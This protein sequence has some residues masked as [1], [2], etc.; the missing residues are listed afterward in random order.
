V[1]IQRVGWSGP[2]VNLTNP[3]D[4]SV[5]LGPSGV[6]HLAVHTYRCTA[7][8]GC[9]SVSAD[10]VARI[11]VEPVL[12]IL[13]YEI[14]QGIQHYNRAGHTDNS[15]ELV[16]GKDTVIRLYAE[17]DIGTFNNGRIP[18][19][20]ATMGFMPV[21]QGY[22]EP[23]RDAD[24]NPITLLQPGDLD[25]TDATHTFNFLLRSWEVSGTLRFRFDVQV[26]DFGGRTAS[27]SRSQSGDR[28]SFTSVKE[29]KVVRV[30]YNWN[31][32]TPSVGDFNG[33]VISI[34]PITPVSAISFWVPEAE[35][36][37]IDTPHNLDT[38]DGLNDALDDLDELAD[39]YEDNG[40][41]WIGM[42]T[43]FN[44][45]MAMTGQ[46][47]QICYV[48]NRM[49]TSHELGHAT[50]LNHIETG[51][52]AGPYDSHDDG[53]LVLDI[54]FDSSTMDAPLDP[55]MDVGIADMMGYPI[56]WIDA[57][58]NTHSSPRWISAQTWGRYLNNLK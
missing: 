19:V 39:E 46:R 52:A 55:S 6:N 27:V 33:E 58:G 32:S 44:R 4:N 41:Y 42:S 24:N 48:G 50:G 49:K 7:T 30:R 53:G 16:S 22:W 9:G 23:D 13:G 15:V 56:E 5:S 29:L 20:T 14:T 26:A 51:S 38:D 37:V 18:D 3:V 31:G 35:D 25:P 11:S 12:R 36:Q 8:N 43:D 57:A 21:G 40:E 1:T 47:R 28:K 45:G 54:P 17:A 34:R 10:V 2:Y